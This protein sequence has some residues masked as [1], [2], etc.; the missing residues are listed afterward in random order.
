MQC[1]VIDDGIPSDVHI[2]MIPCLGHYVISNVH[3]VGQKTGQIL[4]RFLR[5]AMTQSLRYVAT[6]MDARIQICG[7]HVACA[8][9]MLYIRA[10]TVILLALDR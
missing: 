2:M 9:G 1:T 5:S 6:A 10:M 7:H 3:S 8:C 4:A